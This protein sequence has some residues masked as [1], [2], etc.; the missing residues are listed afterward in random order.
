MKLDLVSPVG[1]ASFEVAS[2]R[3]LEIAAEVLE[4]G[5]SADA[6]LDV[7]EVMKRSSGYVAEAFAQLFVTGIWKPFEERGR[8]EEEWGEVVES[9]QRLRPIASEALVAVFRDD[10]DQGGRGRFRPGARAHVRARAIEAEAPAMK[11]AG[12]DLSPVTDGLGSISES[13]RVIRDSVSLLPEVVKNLEEIQKGVRYMADEVHKMR[14]GVDGLGGEVHAMRLAVEPLVEHLDKVS[15]NVEALEPRLED[16]N[17]AIHPFRR[18]T[19]KVSRRRLA[20]GQTAEEAAVD[21]LVQTELGENVSQDDGVAG[22]VAGVEPLPAL[23]RCAV[24]E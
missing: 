2:P 9:I 18:A 24:G 10:D 6:M 17:L 15:A 8:P 21:D 5:V 22:L 7:V 11:I 23:V 19:S 3:L 13:I 16:L 4:R 20:N 14:V 12:I 1:P